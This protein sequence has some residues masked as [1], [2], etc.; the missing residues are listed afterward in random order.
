MNPI[1]RALPIIVAGGIMQQHE[2]EED[3]ENNDYGEEEVHTQTIVKKY[4]VSDDNSSDT[5]VVNV[6]TDIITE[7]TTTTTVTTHWADKIPNE[8]FGIHMSLLIILTIIFFFPIKWIFHRSNVKQWVEYEGYDK[9][10]KERII[11]AI[12]SKLTIKTR[13]AV[14]WICIMF[15][16]LASIAVCSILLYCKYGV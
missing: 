14:I 11:K 8:K 10:D 1:I 4:I 7:P 13:L 9:N 2:K 12:R 16:V 15:S 6:E 5:Y 3:Y